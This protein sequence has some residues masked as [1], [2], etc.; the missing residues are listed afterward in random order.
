MTRCLTISVINPGLY[1]TIQDSGRHGYQRYG[2]PLSGPMDPRASREANL[3]VG[4][5]AQD[6]LMEFTLAGPQLQTSGTGWIAVTGAKVDV[7]LNGRR[8]PMYECIEINGKCT[9]T[10]GLMPKGCR[11][12]LAIRGK[13]QVGQWLSSTSAAPVLGKELTPDSLIHKSQTFEVHS[14]DETSIS[15]FKPLELTTAVLRIMA[16]PEYRKIEAAHLK[17]FLTHKFTVSPQANRMGIRL[18][19]KL[20]QYQPQTEVISS[21]IVT[22]T[23]QITNEGQPIILTADAQTTGGYPRIANIISADFDKTAQ[24]RPGDPVQFELTSITEILKGQHHA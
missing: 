22:G 9:L 3:L 24:L 10:F 17:Y 1:T 7:H 11:S 19:E 21:G 20:P 2:V 16:G 18:N 6:S 15:T 14:G 5:Q 13:W 12:Y 8:V 4:N 23:V